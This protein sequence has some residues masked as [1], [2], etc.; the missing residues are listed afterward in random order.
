LQDLWSLMQFL[1][2]G[3]L[4]SFDKFKRNYALPIERFGNQDA[5]KD[6]KNMVGP[7]ILRRV[8]SDPRVIQDLPEKIEMKEYCQLTEEQATLYEAV[9]QDTLKKI[10]ESDGLARRGLVLALLTHLKQV[11]NHPVQYLHQTDAANLAQLQLDGRSGKL[12]RLIEILEE[13]LAEGDRVLIFTQYAEMGKLLSA[14]LPQ[15]V[16]CSNQYLH[17]GV[18]AKQR[19]QMVR[20]FQEEEHGPPIFI[21][22]LKAGGLGLNLTR[23]NHVL[24]YDRWWNPAVE[25]QATD[26]SFRI[27]QTK[28]VQVHKFITSGTL[29][30]RIDDMIESKKGLADAIIG[31]EQWLTE[32][33]TE[34]LRDLVTLR[35]S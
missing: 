29:E 27:G 1:N 26:R 2:P 14:Y 20:R 12:A 21:L 18:P 5:T 25:D 35:K 16:G 9:V 3:Y 17:G 15:A 28:N 23:A 7:F 6:L 34:E 31:G 10:A 24:H 30:E 8:K 13:I 33:S 19:E 11:C 32:L 22:S 4:G